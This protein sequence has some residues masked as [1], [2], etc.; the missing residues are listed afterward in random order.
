[1]LRP[2]RCR[3]LHGRP[4]HP[5]ARRSGPHALTRLPS[6]AFQPRPG[7]RSHRRPGGRHQQHAGPGAP[8]GDP[9]PCRVR[10]GGRVPLTAGPS[11]P[12]GAA[13]TQDRQPWGSSPAAGAAVTKH[14]T[15]AAEQQARP[16][17][18]GE[19]PRVQAWAAASSEAGT[20]DLPVSRL[21]GVTILWFL[22]EAAP[23]SWPLSPRG[24]PCVLTTCHKDPSHWVTARPGDLILA[25]SS[26]MRSRR[27]VI[28][29]LCPAASRARAG[30][31][32]R[33]AAA[34]GPHLS[35]ASQPPHAALGS[36]G[37]VA[38]LQGEGTRLMDESWRGRGPGNAA[39]APEERN[40]P[41]TPGTRTRGAPPESGAGMA[42]TRSGRGR[43]QR[44]SP[45]VTSKPWSSVTPPSAGGFRAEP[46]VHPLWA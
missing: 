24:A 11:P 18:S 9:H 35:P 45:H 21:L 33:A 28:V 7:F 3:D 42:P 37:D 8:T 26:G 5:L 4:W 46:T 13:H 1:M 25:D 36:D 22:V 15:R 29:S 38:P 30:T 12:P 43:G 44:H 19:R 20:E 10:H 16:S 27:E 34:F 41:R 39:V 17:Q 23:R 31:P 14:P 32:G 2:A 6:R 40:L